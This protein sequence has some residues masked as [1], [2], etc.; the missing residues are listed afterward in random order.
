M[1]PMNVTPGNTYYFDASPNT[2]NTKI[3]KTFPPSKINKQLFLNLT[4]FRI[5]QF[6]YTRQSNIP[7]RTPDKA[8]YHETHGN[9]SAMN[10][11]VLLY[12]ELHYAYYKD[13]EPPDGMWDEKCYKSP[14]FSC[15]P[16]IDKY[17][18]MVCTICHHMSG[19][20]KISTLRRSSW[21]HRWPEHFHNPS[22]N[23]T[24]GTLCSHNILFCFSETQVQ[25]KLITMLVSDKTPSIRDLNQK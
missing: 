5:L 3:R 21:N 16:Y 7:W 25:G 9:S 12:I 4:S 24:L 1:G 22:H 6:H 17:Q 19:S 10:T 13:K 14:H 20:L 2:L 15:Y 8:I 18:E 23:W 11:S